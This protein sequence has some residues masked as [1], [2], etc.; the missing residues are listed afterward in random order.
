MAAVSVWIGNDTWA[1]GDNNA[2]FSAGGFIPGSTLNVDGKLI[3]ERG[4]LQQ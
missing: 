3:V 2:T 1:G 4:A